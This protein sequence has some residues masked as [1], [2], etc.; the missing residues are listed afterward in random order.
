MWPSTISE[1]HTEQLASYRWPQNKSN[2]IKEKIMLSRRACQDCNAQFFLFILY[3]NN[4][5]FKYNVRVLSNGHIEVY[6]WDV[7]FSQIYLNTMLFV[8]LE[9]GGQ[10]K[11]CKI[12]VGVNF[13]FVKS[14]EGLFLILS[15]HRTIFQPPPLLVNND[16]SLSWTYIRMYWIWK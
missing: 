10:N 12:C 7:V 8:H 5:P 9:G 6:S 3:I 2:A 16:R 1:S 13:K 4:F 15:H 11:Y 14:R